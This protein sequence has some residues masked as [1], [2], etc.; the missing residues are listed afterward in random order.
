VAEVATVSDYPVAGP[1]QGDLSPGER[2]AAPFLISRSMRQ[3]K[4]WKRDGEWVLLWFTKGLQRPRHSC[5]ASIDDAIA[6]A[7]RLP[8]WY[9]TSDGRR[10]GEARIAYRQLDSNSGGIPAF[11]EDVRAQLEAIERAEREPLARDRRLAPAAMRG[12]RKDTDDATWP[13]ALRGA[14]SLFSW[15]LGRQSDD[16]GRV[17]GG[18]AGSTAGDP[19]ALDARRTP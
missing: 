6:A 17:A 10:L 5:H 7:H 2:M 11:N 4:K 19:A 15:L 3:D 1:W 12:A 16:R 9:S 13:E 8:R 18:A 14:V